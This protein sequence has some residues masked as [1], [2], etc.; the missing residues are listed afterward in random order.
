MSSVG[1]EQTVIILEVKKTI[2]DSISLSALT[3]KLTSWQQNHVELPSDDLQLLQMLNAVKPALG[4]MDWQQRNNFPPEI[5]A[6]LVEALSD[7]VHS[8]KPSSLDDWLPFEPG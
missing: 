5:A 7:E 4:D 2:V 3:T 8:S 6:N 1:P